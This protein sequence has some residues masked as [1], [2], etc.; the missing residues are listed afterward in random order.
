VSDHDQIDHFPD[1]PAHGGNQRDARWGSRML[2]GM[3]RGIKGEI[4]QDLD[5]AYAA[6]AAAALDY[7][8]ESEHEKQAARLRRN[9]RSRARQR[10]HRR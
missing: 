10:T 9:S 8:Y 6:A 2:V 4:N 1:I 7:P 3:S 5:A